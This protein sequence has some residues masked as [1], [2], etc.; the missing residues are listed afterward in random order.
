MHWGG[1]LI[2]CSSALALTACAADSGELNI[3]PIADPLAKANKSGNP[4]V[5][6]GRNLLA[7]GSVG[8]AVE[9]F[10]KAQRE[11]PY[12]IEAIAGLAEC[13]EQMGRYDLSRSKYEEALAIAPN[14]PVLLNTFAASLERQGLR[15]EAQGL[16]AE[17][18]EAEAASVI[19]LAASAAEAASAEAV[20]PKPVAAK[21]VAR[22]VTRAPPQTPKVEVTQLAPQALKMQV[23]APT[24]PAPK[25]QVASTAVP[26]V[27]VAATT[28]KP[29]SLPP[30]PT[31][32]TTWTFEPSEVAAADL[33]P[34]DSAKPIA[35]NS[36]TIEVADIEPGPR[37]A[38][39]PQIAQPPM[40][41]PTIHALSRTNVVASSQPRLERLSLGEVALVT[42]GGPIWRPQVVAK[43]RQS[44]TVQF[45]PLRPAPAIA[46]VRVLNAA[47]RQGIAA[48]TREVLLDRGWRKIEIGDAPAVRESSLVLYPAHRQA[49]GRSLAAQFGFRSAISN[50]SKELVVLIGRDAAIRTGR[51]SRA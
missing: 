45:I 29:Q 51:R 28:P 43:S 5:V 40:K 1:K 16:R 4:M 2:L 23:T 18:A 39:A 6:E 32:V 30:E 14:N 49:L 15:K 27:Q 13:Y 20:V 44:V 19:V 26:K 37:S 46:N 42:S 9:A 10:R 8:L 25:V 21:Q 34:V 33:A 11:R 38:P 7:L 22:V 41:L 3:R 50:D 48:K 31:G 36:V 35:A 17:A 24:S 12:D 47:R